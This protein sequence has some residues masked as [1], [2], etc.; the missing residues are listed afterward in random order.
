[1]ISRCSVVSSNAGISYWPPIFDGVSLAQGPEQCQ[2]KLA[3]IFKATTLQDTVKRR[4]CQATQTGP[5]GWSV[6]VVQVAPM[7][8]NHIPKCRV[9]RGFNP[10]IQTAH[11]FFEVVNVNVKILT[12]TFKVSVEFV[13]NFAGLPYLWLRDLPYRN[14][15]RHHQTRCCEV[16]QSGYQ[17]SFY[18]T[19]VD[20]SLEFLIPSSIL[21]YHV[22]EMRFNFTFE[23]VRYFN[24]SN[25][26]HGSDPFLPA[27]L[28]LRSH[29]CPLLAQ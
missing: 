23:H 17:G 27:F 3:Q 11:L 25:L 24:Q 10:I 16:H 7:F 13:D 20:Y 28:P 22:S 15:E 6:A 26:P 14:G 29:C 1:M 18:G 21:S 9:T 4:A 8:R 12:Q 5:L 19:V 2:G